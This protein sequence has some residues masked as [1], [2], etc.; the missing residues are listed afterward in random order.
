[1]S[2]TFSLEEYR[3]QREYRENKRKDYLK[4]FEILKQRIPIGSNNIVGNNVRESS[5][6]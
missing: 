1:M 2:S 3:I 4:R 5:K 6:I